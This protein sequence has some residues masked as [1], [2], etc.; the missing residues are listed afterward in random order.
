MSASMRF[1]S[2]TSGFEPDELLG[3]L[4]KIF[5]GSLGLAAAA[6]LALVAVDPFKEQASK[7]PKPLTTKFIKREPRLTKPLELRKLP[8]P[9]RQMVKREVKLAAA[10]MDQVQA[11]ASF[12]TGAVLGQVAN[13]SVNFSRTSAVSSLNLEP[14]GLAPGSLTGTKAPENK[15]DMALEMLDVNSMDTGRYRAMIIQDPNDRQAVSGFV[16]MAQVMSG[17]SVAAGQT[18]WGSINV[19]DVDILRDM[20]NEYTGIKA[21]FLGTIM[22]D[23]E[24]IMEVPIL[25]PQGTPNESELE[26]LSRYLLAGGF[27]IGGTWG[28]ALEKYGGLVSGR[29]FWTERLEEDHPVFTAFFDLRGGVPTGY[30]PGLGS[31]KQGVQSW[32]AVHGYYVKGRLAGISSRQGWGWRNHNYSGDATR[33]LQLA[34]NIIVFDLTQEGGMTQRLMQMVN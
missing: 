6:H 20:L 27:V 2:P 23:D 25:I 12:N 5:V 19:L 3:R 24:R 11:T 28:E 31:G 21:E 34:I 14:R 10:R 4:R 17:R 22:Y 13:P 16:K 1:D 32:N 30:S 26:N 9:K 8:Q 33:P 18:G 15:I 7:A 29:D